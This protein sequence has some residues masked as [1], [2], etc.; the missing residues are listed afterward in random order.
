MFDPNTNFCSTK[1]A[2][3][4]L[5]RE[6]LNWAYFWYPWNSNTNRN[7]IHVHKKLEHAECY[8]STVSWFFNIRVIINMPSISRITKL[9]CT[10]LIRLPL[11][12]AFL[13]T[14]WNTRLQVWQQ[15]YSTFIVNFEH[16]VRPVDIQLDSDKIA[17]WSFFSKLNLP[18]YIWGC[19]SK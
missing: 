12:W 18:Y 3:T 5:T 16:A 1:L 11:N 10:E 6:P 13:W 8:L 9:A 4:K 17:C 15:K 2:C 19:T 7:N 14:H